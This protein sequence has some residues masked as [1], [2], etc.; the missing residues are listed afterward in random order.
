VLLSDLGYKREGQAVVE[1]ADNARVLVAIV[2]RPTDLAR[3]R[4][5]GWYR[6]PVA[7]APRRLA[8]D[9]LA[10][11]QTAAFGDERWAVRYYAA[12]LRYRI[13]RRADLLPSEAAHPRANERYYRLELGP[14]RALPVP[15]PARRLRR[16]TFIATSFGQLR[17]AAD[18]AELW[19]AP[20]IEAPADEVWA[21]GIAGRSVGF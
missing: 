17:R 19:Q 12:I 16:I 5:E 7:R 4:D 3:A 6:V 2:S 13:A 18:V 14:L 8:A 15:V 21:A 1:I 11:Y 9:Y 20:E 10:L